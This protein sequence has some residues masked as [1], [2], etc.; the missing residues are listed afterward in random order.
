MPFRRRLFCFIIK[1]KLFSSKKDLYI[2][3][4]ST[5]NPI[6][7]NLTRIPLAKKSKFWFG[8]GGAG[9]CLSQTTIKKLNNFICKN[10]F[11]KFCKKLGVPNDVTLGFG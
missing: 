4:S 7:L 6:E 5:L 9:F 3:C 8:T 2:G 10:C 1:L 11:E